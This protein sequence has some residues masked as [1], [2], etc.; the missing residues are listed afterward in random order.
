MPKNVNVVGAGLAGLSCAI[1][2]QNAG[3]DVNIFEKTETVGGRVKSDYVDGFILDH[4]F[5]VLPTAYPE[6]RRILDYEALD[7]RRFRSGARIWNEL[8]FHD[9]LD[10]R[11]HKEAWSKIFGPIGSFGDKL[12]VLRF[13]ENLKR[14]SIRNIFKSEEIATWDALTLRNGFS[15]DLVNTFY[16]PFLGGIMLD[17]ELRTSSRMFEFVM[18]MFAEGEAA[19]PAKGMQS[20]SDQ[21]ASRLERGTVNF[22]SGVAEIAD[23]KLILE[24]RETFDSDILIIATDNPSASTLDPRVKIKDSKSV[25]CLY[26]SLPKRD[27][28]DAL[29][30]LNG[31]GEGR[32]NNLAFISHIAPEY[33]PPNQD[34]VSISV[35]TSGESEEELRA[36][37]E[38][39]LGSWFGKESGAWKFLRMYDIVHAQPDQSIPENSLSERS[40]VLDR[41]V[42]IAGD[43]LTTASIN[44][45]IQSGRKTADI[46]IR[47]N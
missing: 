38:K 30:Y 1:D 44:G 4:G 42:F 43:Y 29:L 11:R 17:S 20:I 41:D 24:N 18:K 36:D 40:Q 22:G 45:A 16:K 28:R 46:I 23:K 12:K 3:F 34:L 5:Q 47:S 19:I 8:E 15:E 37:V 31:S 14:R 9:I 35:L 13:S 7:L 6:T 26:Y 2:L 33:A 21:L 10:P 32:I 25:T 27:S 39:E